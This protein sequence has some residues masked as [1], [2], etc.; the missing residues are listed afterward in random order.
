MP[1]S[2]DTLL[3]RVYHFSIDQ[4]GPRGILMTYA[5]PGEAEAIARSG[6][7]TAHTTRTCIPS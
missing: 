4:P 6:R 5:R 2:P 3:R 7:R 1:T